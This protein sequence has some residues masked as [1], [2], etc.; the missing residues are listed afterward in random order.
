MVVCL[1]LSLQQSELGEALSDKLEVGERR[2]LTSNYTLTTGHTTVGA[3]LLRGL[4]YSNST[5][6]AVI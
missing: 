2:S 3:G 1:S 6:L 5:K 4:G